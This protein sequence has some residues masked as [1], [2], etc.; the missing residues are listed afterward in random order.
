VLL[1]SGDQTKDEAAAKLLRSQLAILEQS[2]ELPELAEGLGG[3]MVRTD[4]EAPLRLAFSVVEVRRDDADE[5]AFVAMLL[6]AEPDLRKFDE[7]IAFPVFGRGRVLY[8]LVGRGINR[9]NI[10]EACS[11]LVGPCSCQVKGGNPG[12]DMLMA[13]DWEGLVD[14]G[15][16]AEAEL[17]PL[18]GLSEV[19][20]EAP[21]AL[22]V[23]P[24]EAVGGTAGGKLLRNVL[25]MLGL[26]VVVMVVALLLVRQRSPG[27]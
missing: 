15:L 27:I 1:D 25:I 3:Y 17:P 5:E 9:D 11:F 7:P 2:L 6:S 12:V 14:Q 19:A 4:D 22:S 24:A 13:V 26:L 21:D 16:V 23:P 18:M 20:T 8:A 10:T